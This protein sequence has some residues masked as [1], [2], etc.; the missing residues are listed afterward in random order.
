MKSLMISRRQAGFGLLDAALAI[1]IYGALTMQLL[2]VRLDLAKDQEDKIAAQH[3]Q[4]LQAGTNAFINENRSVL[5]NS[6]TP[7]VPGFANPMAP[8]VNELQASTSPQYLPQGYQ[9]TNN[10]GMNMV[11]RL[12][13]IPTGCTPGVSCTDIAGLVYSTAPLV[14]EAMNQP[15]IARVGTMATQVGDDGAFSPLGAPATFVGSAGTWTGVLNP[16]N[17]PAILAVRAGFGSVGYQSLDY[18]LPRDGSRPMV[19]TL[20]M[21]GND[22]VNVG[23]VTANNQL[24]VKDTTACIRAALDSAGGFYSRGVGCVVSAAL[25]NSGLQLWNGS[26]QNTVSMNSSALVMSDNPG[27]GIPKVSI[28][29]TG[30]VAATDGTQTRAQLRGATGK[31]ETFDTAGAPAVT[32]D[33]GAPFGGRLA[34]NG[35]NP[36]DLP[37]GWSGGVRS[38]DVLANGTVG[39]WDGTT[40]KSYLNAAGDSFVANNAQVQNVLQLNNVST[41]NTACPVAGQQS[42]NA[43]GA[44][45]SCVNNGTLLWLKAGLTV[46]VVGQPCAPDGSLAQDLAQ[47]TLLCRNGFY[48]P[49]KDFVASVIDL[50]SLPVT[51]GQVVPK[52]SCGTGGTAS[53][54]IA[55]GTSQ[56]DAT[57]ILNVYSLDNGS[58]W[59][60]QI[61]SGGGV[62]AGPGPQMAARVACIYP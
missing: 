26:G 12:T 16:V 29:T 60:V 36:N 18:L 35:L 17:Q 57:G 49:F 54:F 53:L 42:R 50:D 19:G 44:L 14:D 9:A 48:A 41:E 5:L 38:I 58:S 28:D 62:A 40:V 11:I 34:T 46:G 7:A 43:S 47:D 1:V 20:M 8:T 33:G 45:L 27:V 55:N 4:M 37:S 3:A 31:V 51:H 59:T 6:A 56:T 23:S 2:T 52:P 39:T 25:T 32:L 30:V 22:I 21:G 13:R 10:L 15:D 24:G 61:T